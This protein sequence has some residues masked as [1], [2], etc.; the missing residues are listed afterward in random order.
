VPAPPLDTD[1]VHTFW[2]AL[3][4]ELPKLL[5]A[6]I[7]AALAWFVGS[8]ITAAWDMRKKRGEF[9]ILLAK[10][11]YTVVASFKAVAREWEAHLRLKP[12]AN[13]NEMAVWE[14]A[15]IALAKRALDAE[16]SMESIL[17][18]LVTEGAGA[19]GTSG[20]EKHKRQRSLSLFRVAFRNLRETV[21]KGQDSPPGWGHPE[22]WLFNRLAGEISRIVY[23]RSVKVPRQ[24]SSP[25][26]SVSAQDYLQLLTGR[27]TDLRLAARRLLPAVEAFFR[28]RAQD[29]AAARRAN[30]ER[31]FKHGEFECVDLL[32]EPRRPP[33]NL[34]SIPSID[35]AVK[36]AVEVQHERRDLTRAREA[37]DALFT[38]NR[39]LSHYVVLCN[40]PARVLVFVPG[41]DAEKFEELDELDKSKVQLPWSDRTKTLGAD[42]LAWRLSDVGRSR[43]SAIATAELGGS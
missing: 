15:R 9:D 19:E 39:H 29:R 42:L 24:A 22:F 3:V 17:L 12:A 1:L 10:E 34:P 33:P 2:V 11:F 6:V 14:T 36:A 7:V 4:G 40:E 23:E 41:Q 31:L 32:P 30:V 16:T 28:Q 43:L 8:R 21:E 37:A 35:T 13:T 38:A 20:S 26:P 5:T 25:A 18:K 27:T